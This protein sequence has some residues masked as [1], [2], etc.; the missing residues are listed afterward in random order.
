MQGRIYIEDDPFEEI[1]RSAYEALRVECIGKL[2][3]RAEKDFNWVIEQAHASQLAYRLPASVDLYDSRD[4]WSFQGNYIGDYH[5]HVCLRGTYEG[6][7][8]PMLPKPNFS[9]AD[10]KDVKAGTTQIELVIA[11]KKVKN[12]GRINNNPRLISGYILDKKNLCRFDIA[13]CY[14][15]SV[16]RRAELEISDKMRRLIR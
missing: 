3:G 13:A 14:Y 7:R 6:I 5:S 1:L 12:L 4:E 11:I 15:N 2:F 16:I 9:Q 10:L 8:L